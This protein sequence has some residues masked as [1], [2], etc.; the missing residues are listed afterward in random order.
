MK[1]CTCCKEVKSLDEFWR[2]KRSSDGLQGRCKDCKRQQK[3][4]WKA[5]NPER[6]REHWRRWREKQPAGTLPYQRRWLEQNSERNSETKREWKRANREK[7]NEAERRRRAGNLEVERQRSREYQH[8][9]RTLKGQGTPETMARV[10]ELVDDP[11]VYCGST[12]N[13]EIDHIVPLSRGGTH[14]PENLAPACRP[15]NR[16]KGAKLLSEWLE[17]VA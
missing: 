1:T 11:C 12:E 4:A 7:V 5:T 9:R 14:T 17:A 15:C 13:I 16:S 3:R 8:R 6:E 2:Y 10:A